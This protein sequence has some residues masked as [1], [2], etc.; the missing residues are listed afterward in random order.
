[1][2]WMKRFSLFKVEV[3]KSFNIAHRMLI[4]YFVPEV[5]APDVCMFNDKH[6]S[7]TSIDL[8]A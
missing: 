6:G 5:I 2:L 3:L 7:V 4:G 8:Q 1:V